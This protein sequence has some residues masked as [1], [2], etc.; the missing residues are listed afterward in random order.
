MTIKEAEKIIEQLKKEN[1]ALKAE[2]AKYDGKKPAGRRVHDEKWTANYDLWV[3]L[4]E[5][6]HTIVEITDMT[7]FSRRTCYRYLEYYKSRTE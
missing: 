3:S 7:G 6:G 5:K 4:Y 2:L 1:D